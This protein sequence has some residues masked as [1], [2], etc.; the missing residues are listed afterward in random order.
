MDLSPKP[1]VSDGG[2]HRSTNGRRETLEGIHCYNCGKK[3]HISW[4][5]PSNAL[6]CMEWEEVG[7]KRR[8]TV[9][10]TEVRDIMLETGCTR[11]MV[12]GDLISKDKILE[13]KSV[14]VRWAHGDTVLY[15]VCM[16][17]D[18]CVINTVAVVSHTLPLAVLLGVDVPE[19]SSLFLRRAPKAQTEVSEAF[20]TTRAGTRR[21]DATRERMSSL[22][23]D[24]LLL[25]LNRYG[26]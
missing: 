1:A 10:R 6:C 21:K 22:E 17:V 16:E 8:G 7:L 26:S 14:V 18:G 23:Y 15:Q 13:G 4:N 25:L 11:T 2:T 20:V 19:L 24:Q 12:R 5:C 9:E 3:G